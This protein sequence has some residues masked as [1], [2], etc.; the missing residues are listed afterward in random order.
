MKNKNLIL[1]LADRY[2]GLNVYK[3]LDLLNKTQYFSTKELEELQLN[4]LK[5]LI[6]YSG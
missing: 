6:K 1:S 2:F 4:Y 3:T 5:K